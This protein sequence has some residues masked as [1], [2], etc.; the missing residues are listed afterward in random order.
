MSSTDQTADELAAQILEANPD[1]GP[2]FS[3]IVEEVNKFREIGLPDEQIAQTVPGK[4][5]VKE[6]SAENNEL[7]QP[8][9][10]EIRVVS[11]PR[12]FQ[13]EDWT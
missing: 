13:R 9:P 7:N 4:F 5:R 11:V 10:E 2:L 1:I 3:E 8:A 12:K 6:Q